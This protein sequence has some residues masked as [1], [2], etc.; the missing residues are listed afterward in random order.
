MKIKKKYVK[1]PVVLGLGFVVLLFIA[2][3]IVPNSIPAAAFIEIIL[4]CF[5]VAF[6][7]VKLVNENF[8]KN[9]KMAMA[10]AFFIFG[11]LSTAVLLKTGTVDVPAE[12]ISPGVLLISFAFLAVI[13][14]VVYYFLGMAGTLAYNNLKKRK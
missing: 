5:G 1:N 8:A 3:Y 2:G 13:S 4:A 11:G 7:Y 12:S 9:Q 14:L 6:A 10:I